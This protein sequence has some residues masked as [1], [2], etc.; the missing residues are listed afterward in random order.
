[1]AREKKR[2]H[3]KKIL[4]QTANFE[5]P[6]Q[7]QDVWNGIKDKKEWAE[8]EKTV[9]KPNRAYTPVSSPQQASIGFSFIRL[10]QTTPLLPTSSLSSLPLGLPSPSFL[11]PYCYAS[12]S[13]IH[14]K[15]KREIAWCRTVI[16]LCAH[17]HTHPPHTAQRNCRH[18]EW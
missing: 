8:E 7:T 15:E 1:M 9:I 10:R 12:H 11:S 13:P 17:P 14:V 6:C 2:A 5:K 3:A 4:D 16:M 18:E